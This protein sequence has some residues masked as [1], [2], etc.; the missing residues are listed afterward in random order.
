MNR[1]DT[2]P[3]THPAAC[4]E[5]EMRRRAAAFARLMQGRRTVRHFSGRPVPREV[6]Q[7]AL[8]AAG[9]AP[10]GANCQPWHFVAVADPAVKRR[11]RQAAEEGER[12]F[13]DGRAADA[14]LRAL[15]PL[16]TGPEKPFLEAAP[17]LIAVFEQRYGVSA[18]GG[19]VPHYYPH[20]S[21]G[22]ATGILI[23]ALH[24]SGLAVLPYTPSPMGFLNAILDRP[25]N[26]RP[27]VLLVAGHAAQGATVPAIP[28]KG[29]EDIATFL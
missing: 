9:A 13:Y 19:K 2:I 29:L 23:A 5:A 16:G 24:A 22:I 4:S 1:P 11:I 28:R 25:A 6:I 14:W 18:D 20:A 10:S 27:F 17:W 21:V 12:R 15:E 8:R 26:E 7:D 3:Y